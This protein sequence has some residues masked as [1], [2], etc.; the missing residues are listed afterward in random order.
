MIPALKTALMGAR[1]NTPEHFYARSSKDSL[2][3]PLMQSACAK[4]L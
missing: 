3:R 2:A 4:I 1:T